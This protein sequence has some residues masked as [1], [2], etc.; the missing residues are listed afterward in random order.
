M[1]ILMVLDH[2]FPPDIRVE[3]E[4]RTLVEAGFEVGLLSIGPDDGPEHE[5]YKG[6]QIFRDRVNARARNW[7]RG[8]SGTLKLPSRLLAGR[9][10]KVYA[11]WPFDALHMHDLYLFGGGIQAASRLGVP[12]VGDLHENW[13]EALKHYAWS[14]RP[15]AKWVISIPRWEKLEAQWVN[16]VDR[17]IVV[18]REAAGRSEALGVP[19]TRIVEVPN[20]VRAEDFDAYVID[21]DLVARV[22][23]GLTIVYTGGMD[24][25]RGLDNAIRSMSTVAK[26]RPDAR[27]ILVG[28]GRVRADLEKLVQTEGL[29][30]HVQFE[31]WRTQADV[32]SYIEAADVCLVPH[33]RTAHTDATLPHK[34][35]HYMYASRPVVV[36]DCS[37]L[38]RIVS[39]EKC[40]RVVPDGDASAMGGAILEIAGDPVLAR[41]M[42]ERG[43]EAVQRRWNWDATSVEMV[44]MYR[45]LLGD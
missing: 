37:P 6:F 40:G 1:R 25:H 10:E 31:G 3:N 41:R 23:S 45:D 15:P 7:A 22:K 44:A 28:D 17:L 33:R 36:T 42:A 32:R 43:R 9:I 35:F 19:P 16:A 27:L 18:V 5:W 11:R 30:E 26:S 2:S 20:T 4:A 34:L 38:D 39:A 12:L 21:Q 8:L 29:D 13:V 14:S 24:I